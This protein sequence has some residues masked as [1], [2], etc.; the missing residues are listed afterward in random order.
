LPH[1]VIEAMNCSVPVVATNIRGTNEAIDDGRTGLL[2]SLDNEEGFANQIGRLFE[3][4]QLSKQLVKKALAA[5]AEKFSW[6]NNLVKLETE[7][8]KAI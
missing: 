8:E 1:T 2:V 7:L 3:D 6:E 5:V 4:R